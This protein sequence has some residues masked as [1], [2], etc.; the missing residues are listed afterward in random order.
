METRNKHI[1][2]EDIW[3]YLN[4]EMT[5]KQRARFT[6][7]LSHCSNCLELTRVNLSIK[8]EMELGRIMSHLPDTSSILEKIEYWF[9]KE[10]NNLSDNHKRRIENILAEIRS[11]EGV[12]FNN[13]QLIPVI[14]TTRS[15]LSYQKITVDQKNIELLTNKNKLDL[16]QLDIEYT[17]NQLIIKSDNNYLLNKVISLLGIEDSHF[18]EVQFKHKLNQYIAQFRGVSSKKYILFYSEE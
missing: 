8:K 12:W 17:D 14:A 4:M 7:H 13:L 11:F 2:N 18:Q 6:S 9:R 1:T 15:A 3:R 5:I 16:D 10:T